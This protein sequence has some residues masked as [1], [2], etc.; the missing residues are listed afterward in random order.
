MMLTVSSLREFVP[1]FNGNSEATVSEQI[2]VIHKAP[3]MAIKERVMP[4][5][6]NL[7]QNGNTSIH[8][9]IDRKKIIK[10]F[11]TEIV[12]CSYKF[13]SKSDEKDVVCRIKDTESLFNAPPEFDGLIDE[14][15]TY[16]QELLNT[17]VPEK[18]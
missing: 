8:V 7:D 17:K 6:F 2:K 3:T 10:E 16:Y 11:G 1:K 9:E 15:Y 4:R 13:D 12:N 18:N 14:L 5:A